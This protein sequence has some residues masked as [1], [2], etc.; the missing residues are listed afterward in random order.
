[1]SV[2]SEPGT[3]TKT[4]KVS[5][6]TAEEKFRKVIQCRGHIKD[7]RA[8]PSQ[9]SELQTTVPTGC[10]ALRKCSVKV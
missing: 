8:D 2:T 3:D 1:M 9:A 6:S 4:P 5:S 7:Y 10:T